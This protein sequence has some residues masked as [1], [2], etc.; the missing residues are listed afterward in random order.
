MAVILIFLFL[1]FTRPILAQESPTATPSASPTP[2]EIRLDITDSPSSPVTIGTEFS[3]SISLINAQPNTKYYFK[4]KTVDSSTTNYFY[5]KCNDS[6]GWCHYT[7]TFTDLPNLTTD[8]QGQVSGSLVLRFQT[9]KA[10]AG[11]YRVRVNYE[12]VKPEGSNEWEE[13]FNIVVVEA[14]APENTPIPSATNTPNPTP[15][16]TPVPTTKPSSTPYPTSTP[17]I[18]FTPTPENTLTPTEIPTDTP[19]PEAQVLGDID[20]SSDIPD[21]Y[22]FDDASKVSTASAKFTI[23]SYAPYFLIIVGGGLLLAPAIFSKFSQ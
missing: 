19:E 7:S 12:S 1:F 5:Y 14:V 4:P 20:T 15:T 17:K 6:D 22:N 9:D 18:T 2:A 23:R 10:T 8:S 3:I 13:S 16:S 11:T 21:I